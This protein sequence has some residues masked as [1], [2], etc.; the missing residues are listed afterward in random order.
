MEPDTLATA[1][2]PWRSLAGGTLIG[3]AAVAPMALHGGGS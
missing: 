2:T 1:F 3:L